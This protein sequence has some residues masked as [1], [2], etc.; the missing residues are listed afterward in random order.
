MKT[1]RGFYN[2]KPKDI[3]CLDCGE[4]I[5]RLTPNHKRCKDCA[6]KKVLERARESHSHL[7]PEENRRRFKK[8]YLLNI[9]RER[10][11]RLKRWHDRRR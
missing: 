11:V 3:Q 10:K 5:I 9:D 8:W 6:Y 4:V 1:V 2:S 7:P